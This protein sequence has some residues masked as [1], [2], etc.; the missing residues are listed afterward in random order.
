MLFFQAILLNGLRKIFSTL[1][2]VGS[3]ECY[4]LGEKFIAETECDYIVY[5]ECE[6]FVL[7]ILYYELDEIG[8]RVNIR[9]VKYI[10]ESGKFAVNLL[11]D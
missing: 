8:G 3:P 2:F 6:K 11:A 4:A 9:S 5:R 1:K 7:D 10:S